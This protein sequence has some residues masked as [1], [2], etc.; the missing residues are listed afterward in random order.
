MRRA[1]DEKGTG[2]GGGERREGKNE[3]VSLRDSISEA[4]STVDDD[5]GSRRISDLPPRFLAQSTPPTFV[6]V[7]SRDQ[8]V[9]LNPYLR[10][11]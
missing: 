2:R 9:P 6:F 7:Y 8:G 10:Y 5:T 11:I 3:M 1:L 4:A